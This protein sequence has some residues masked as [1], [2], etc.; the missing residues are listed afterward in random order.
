M[1]DRDMSSPYVVNYYAS[2]QQR[3]EYLAAQKYDQYDEIESGRNV[4]RA[5]TRPKELRSK[6]VAIIVIMIILLVAYV[7]LAAL[8]FFNVLPQYTSTF[9]KNPGVVLAAPAEETTDEEATEEETEAEAAAEDEEGGEEDVT[10]EEETT[11]EEE[12]T[13]S[14]TEPIQLSNRDIIMGFVKSFT[15]MPAEESHFYKD[16]MSQVGTADTVTKIAYYALPVAYAL[17]LLAAV[18]QLIGAI[19]A[20]FSRNRLKALF[21]IL[22][23]VML[24]MNILVIFA[25]YVWSAGTDFTYIAN[26]IPFI[27]KQLIPIQLGMGGL[28]SLGISLLV[29]IFSFFTYR[30]KKRVG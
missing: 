14:T 28:I 18:V 12:A 9:V 3:Q 16:A 2:R 23:I 4:G 6:R 7:A 15:Q 10:A 26:Y 25:G 5:K 17:A 1:N 29:F 19:I 22:S 30:S 27:A 20:A 21:V 24:V 8:S 11:E 13:T